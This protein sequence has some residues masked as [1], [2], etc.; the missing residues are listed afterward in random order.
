MFNSK[1][2]LGPSALSA[3]Q[4]YTNS[5]PPVKCDSYAL[6]GH[7]DTVSRTH[8]DPDGF[9]TVIR[10]EEGAKG[11]G[12][13]LDEDLDPSSQHLKKLYDASKRT[14]QGWS[15]QYCDMVI[16]RKGDTL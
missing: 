6:S 2:T 4:K 5:H 1:L 16:L 3:G 14:F 9:G 13:V 15:R 7:K 11:W 10:V 8:Q 12:V